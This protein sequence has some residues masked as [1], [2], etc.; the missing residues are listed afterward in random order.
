MGATQQV[1]LGYGASALPPLDAYSTNLATAYS[2][3]RRLLTAYTGPLIRVER[4]SDNTQADIGYASSGGLDQAALLAFTGAGSGYI[5]TIY[6]QSGGGLNLTALSYAAMPRVV[7]AG[8]VETQD[9]NPCGYWDGTS[10]ILFASYSVAS[11][12]PLTT[13]WKARLPNVTTGRWFSG[14][15]NNFLMGAGNYYDVIYCG[16]A[17]LWGSLVQDS[18]NSHSVA[19][20]GPAS[21]TQALYVDGTL[22]QSVAV[23]GTYGSSAPLGLQIGGD[24]GHFGSSNRCEAY[25]AEFFIY[26]VVLTGADITAISALM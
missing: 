3:R 22:T 26:N 19:F 5:A 1:I 6:D 14:N 7:N 10:S 25:A 16:G 20:T 18:A 21:G 15:G 13:F 9:S 8:T 17:V 4:S 23:D 11:A 12:R 24:A 2:V